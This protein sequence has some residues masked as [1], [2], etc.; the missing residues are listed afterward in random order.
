VAHTIDLSAEPRSVLGKKVK[1]LR[2][3]GK[4]PANL[5]GHGIESTP[6]QVDGKALQE[7]LRHATSTTLVNLKVGSRAKARPVFVR[8]VRYG[9][10]KREPLH[11][12]FF[13]VRMDEKMR[14]SI[15]IVFRGES[16]AARDAELMLFHPVASVQVEGLPGNLPEALAIDI[17]HL[18]EVDQTI[19]ARDLQMPE[20]VALLDDPEELLVRVQMVRAA[21]EPVAPEEIGEAAQAAGEEA[22]EEAP[23]QQAPTEP[24]GKSS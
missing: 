16:P 14:A 11:V 5:Y 13:A 23:T 10:I 9:L 3:E 6:I 1:H 2:A 21:V 4:I 20:G 8:D 19:Y 18:S 15:P 7:T 17:S 22:A 12:D 24:E